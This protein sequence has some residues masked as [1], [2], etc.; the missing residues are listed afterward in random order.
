MSV[1]GT[2]WTITINDS[3][4]LINYKPHGDGGVGNQT[5]NGWQPWYL[6]QG[7]ITNPGDDGTG[8]SLHITAFPES[9][10]EL[11]FYGMS[12]ALYGTTNC[13]YDVT[14]D[15]D[16]WPVT[17]SDDLLFSKDDLAPGMHTILSFDRAFVSRPLDGLSTPTP[18]VYDN[19]N[20]SF[21]TYSGNW[22]LDS[23]PNN[24]IPSTA[25]PAPY[26]TVSDPGASL[27][28]NFNG[29]AIAVNGPRNWGGYTYNVTVDGTTSVFNGSTMWLVG[30]AL[31]Y[32][33]DGMDPTQN[34]TL[35]IIPKTGDGLKFWLN[36]ITVYTVNE[37]SASANSSSRTISNMFSSSASSTP[38]NSASSPVSGPKKT[39]AGAIVG[40]I[41][42]VLTLGIGVG[43]SK[44]ARVQDSLTGSASLAPGKL[45][46]KGQTVV[47][48]VADGATTI[49]V[50][51]SDISNRTTPYNTFPSQS[52]IPSQSLTPPSLAIDSQSPA[53]QSATVDRL[54]ELIAERIDQRPTR[55]F[56]MDSPDAPPPQYPS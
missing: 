27:S 4:P 43:A 53:L 30:D 46:E 7:F 37:A 39:N 17:G 35:E 8:E 22:Q 21:I 56:P 11:Q 42:A 50:A 33:Q 5:A 20:T 14:I 34:H 13:T 6:H 45:P 51:S 10:L 41:V 18:T 38:S 40:A 47:Y 24:Q 26:H 1:N 28:I 3:S 9:S 52:A 48:S 19:Q 23:D 54:L 15:N 29:A 36:S 16:A 25:H 12:I 31:L 44:G 49:S 55:G 2:N 32:Y